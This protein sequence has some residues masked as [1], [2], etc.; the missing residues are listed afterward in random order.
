MKKIIICNIPVQEKGDKIQYMSNDQSLPTSDQAYMYPINSFLSQTIK[1]ND[2]LKVILLIKKDEKNFYEAH[3]NTFKQEMDN[4]CK[5]IG[6]KVEYVSIATAF[7]QKK[8]S[9]EQLIIKLIDEIDVKAHIMIDIT[10]ASKDFPIIIFTVLNFVEKF[11]DC[12]ID[13]II[14][15]QPEF[16]QSNQVKKAEIC[17]MIPLY[18]L[19]SVT[20]II[21]CDDPSKAKQMMKSLLTL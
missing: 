12:E 17:D 1:S 4:I 7:N 2:E 20:D 9:H 5:N 10:Y 16:N 6:I 19:N 18:Y 14:Y 21:Q 3:I 11:F 8:A 15:C 13:N